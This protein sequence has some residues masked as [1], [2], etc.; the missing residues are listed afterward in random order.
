MN[1]WPVV[2]VGA[3][4]GDPGLVTVRG[5]E[6]LRRADVILYDNLA[7]PALLAHARPDAEII[8]VG[9][10]RAEHALTQDEINALLVEHARAGRRVVRLKGGDP[11]LFGRG[12]EE[13]EALAG[14]GLPFEV[15]PGVSSAMGAAACAGIPLTHRDHTSAVTFVTGH[16]VD[17]IDWARTGASETIVVFMGL[18]TFPEIARRL[19]AAGRS[20]ETPAAAV[21]WATRRDQRTIQGTL[22]D[23]AGKIAETCLKPPTIIIVGEV[24]R[25]AEKLDW[26]ERLPL[27]G[28]TI[29]VTRA[30]EQAGVLSARLAELG[31]R[32]VEIPTIQIEP[33]LDY[34][35]LDA[36]IGRLESF[37]W[38]IFTSANGV[39]FFLERL[40][41]SARDLR[42]VRGRICAIGPATAAA[43]AALHLKIDLMPE[44]YV[45]ESVIR[46]FEKI[47][48]E[49]ARILLP[50]AAVARDLIP[51]ELEKRG[52]RV[53]VVEAYRTVPA[54]DARWPDDL[55]PD[56]VLFTSSSTA[57]NFVSL[58]GAERLRGVRVASIGPVTSATARRL[59][60]EVSVE[61]SRHS[62]E[63]LVEAL[64][65]A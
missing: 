31:A 15:V 41:G 52:A 25:L 38:L 2:L 19:I 65:G 39:R 47:P 35:P 64:L 61:A 20:P 17:K 7:A 14:A 21:R 9:K 18:V 42:A 6:C 62:T 30:R 23:L 58:F 10:K 54:R 49:G 60:V 29:V 43:L 5:L 46:A 27:F 16:E 1:I 37:D 4:P 45:A 22:A 36:A 24:V 50:R 63:G 40:D 59:G 26:F 32:V 44:E 55:H 51:V 56:W 3:G 12:G 33:A 11:F 48:L 8:Y 28:R 53:L 13:A 57:E 34:G